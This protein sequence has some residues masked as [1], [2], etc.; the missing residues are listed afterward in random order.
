MDTESMG[1]YLQSEY[2]W[3]GNVKNPLD[4]SFDAHISIQSQTIEV[5][6][7]SLRITIGSYFH[8]DEFLTFF[9]AHLTTRRRFGIFE[10][11]EKKNHIIQML[12]LKRILTVHYN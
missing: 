12:S 10:E 3:I 6:R 1:K 9:T 5:D 2:D 7:L 8:G 11:T 4:R